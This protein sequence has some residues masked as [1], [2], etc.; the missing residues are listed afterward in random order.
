MGGSKE[1]VKLPRHGVVAQRGGA[2][3]R[4]IRV[5]DLRE[6]V[7]GAV[8]VFCCFVQDGL[9]RLHVMQVGVPADRISD[10][11]ASERPC[12]RPMVSSS[13]TVGQPGLVAGP[14]RPRE[15]SS[16]AKVQKVVTDCTAC[17]VSLND[18][19]ISQIQSRGNH[20]ERTRKLGP[21]RAFDCSDPTGLVPAL[22]SKKEWSRVRCC[23]DTGNRRLNRTI[24]TQ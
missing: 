8:S 9:D 24:A 7:S 2:S 11:I 23:G 20:R 6:D 19:Q 17:S 3:D 10:Q 15:R 5:Q 16:V 21:N 22:I 14:F 1:R 13:S 12:H 4:E 18:E